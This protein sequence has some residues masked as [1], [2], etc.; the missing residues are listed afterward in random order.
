M[1]KNKLEL[2][3][4]LGKSILSDDLKFFMNQFDLPTDPK[5][6]LDY[7]GNAYDTR[8]DNESKGIYLNFDGYIRYKYNYGEPTQRFGTSKDELFLFEV[9]IENIFYNNKKPLPIELPFNLQ[10]DD[11]KEI[12]LQKL[13]K[14][15][16]EKSQSSYGY[17]WW[18][19]FDGF[20]ILTA[21]NPEFKLIWIRIIKLTLNEQ[22]KEKIKKFLN[23]QRKNIRSE[24]SQKILDYLNKLPTYLWKHRKDDG[25]YFF[26]DHGI[27]EV[28]SLLKNYLHRLAD[29]TTQKKAENIYNSIKKI[30][31][32]LNKI[33]DKN[34]GF[35]ETVE[36][37]ELSDFINNVLRETGL[38]IDK[39]IDLTEEWREW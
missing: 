5:L 19:R 1:N 24:N 27:A 28:E 29:L 10:F 30:V 22:E 39:N 37:E 2:T 38:D 3:E 16:Y 13:G 20:R 9:T 14:K 17:S 34:G 18:T 32:S 6:N 36:R 21:L 12:V 33:N 11:H 35:I 23:Q 4:L 25:D 15:P 8:S 7:Q 31:V 26:K